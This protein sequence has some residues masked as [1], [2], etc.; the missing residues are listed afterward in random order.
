VNQDRAI[1]SC[2]NALRADTQ[3]DAALDVRSE[4]EF[5]DDHLPGAVNLPVL[6]DAERAEIGTLHKQVSAFDARRRGAALV[7]RNIAA[8]V[9]GP[10]ADKPRDWTPLVYC[11]RGG[12]RSAALVHVLQRIGWRA[13]QLEGGYRAYRRQVLLDLVDLP[14][15]LEFQVLCGTTG[16]GKSRLLQQ[17]A[18]IGAQVLDLEQLANHRGSVLGGMPLSPQPSQKM[19]ESRLWSALRALHADA[20]V[21]VESESRKVG[22]LRVPD[23]LVT[24]MRTAPCIRIELPLGERV[25]LLR[26]EYAHFEQV[27]ADLA[28]KLDCLV[29]LHGHQRIAQWK[30]LASAGRWD[31][32]VG[33]LLSE[34]YD[35]AYLRSIRRNFSRI[36]AARTVSLACCET[37]AFA[38][39]ALKLAQSKPG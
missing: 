27:P 8:I 17:L 26:E 6:H 33:C 39:A 9:E 29:T 34:H 37:E 5:A 24:A 3:F 30:G 12:Q 2:A 18:Q 4:G 22:D 7:A 25:K 35:P 36:D 16:S 23:A 11:W 20:P 28:A 10:L 32:M 38:S 13:Q 14:T 19:F 1:V 15:G 31:D 21:F